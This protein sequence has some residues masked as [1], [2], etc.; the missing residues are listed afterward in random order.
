M[1][2]SLPYFYGSLRKVK[3]VEN[4]ITGETMKD[5]LRATRNFLL[6]AMVVV[7]VLALF[8]GVRFALFVPLHNETIGAK[9]PALIAAADRGC[10]VMA[11]KMPCFR[12]AYPESRAM[13][14]VPLQS[15]SADAETIAAQDAR[16]A[17]QQVKFPC[18][19]P[20]DPRS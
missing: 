12:H 9:D 5:F 8:M 16:C 4:L 10:G 17:V 19:Q 1:P 6:G 15:G 11:V 2:H 14:S 13:A 20:T 3:T 18:L 7:A